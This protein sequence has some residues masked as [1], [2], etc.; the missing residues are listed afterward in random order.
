MP[1]ATVNFLIL[2]GPN[3]GAS[4]SDVTD[5]NGEATFTY[6]DTGFFDD[7]DTIQAT[8]GVL[9]FQHSRCYLGFRSL[10]TLVW[11]RSQ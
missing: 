2:T 6:T 8:I 3:A 1:G 9:E 10:T 5:A 7:T 4:G 11:T